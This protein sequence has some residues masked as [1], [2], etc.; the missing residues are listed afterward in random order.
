MNTAAPADLHAEKA[1]LGT[2]LKDPALHAIHGQG[3]AGA[4]FFDERHRFAA[5]A[6]RRCADAGTPITVVTVT[7]ELE[8]MRV[9]EAAGGVAFVEDLVEDC[10]TVI[11]IAHH[12]GI[13]R[14]L[15]EQR[16]L[17]AGLLNLVSAGYGAAAD[18]A[19]T[20]AGME[21]LLI[22]ARDGTDT[23]K[24]LH[25]GVHLAEA[26]QG[27][28]ARYQ[29]SDGPGYTTGIFGL[30]EVFAMRPP[31][32]IVVGGEPGSGKTALTEQLALHLAAR[33]QLVLIVSIEMSGE[34][35]AQRAIAGGLGV[36]MRRLRAERMDAGEVGEVGRMAGELSGLPIWIDDRSQPSLADIR[37]SVRR[38]SALVGKPAIVFVDYLGLM[39]DDGGRNDS[40]SDRATRKARGLRAMAKDFGCVV[41]A[42]TQLVKDPGC[43]G[44][45][46]R[47]T[48]ASIRDSKEIEA[49]ADAIVLVWRHDAACPDEA[50]NGEA[51]ILIAKQRNDK[52][53]WTVPVTFDG[54]AMK[55]SDSGGW[56]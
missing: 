44:E 9:L 41:V 6:M 55:F 21:R 47:P 30:D 13:V 46:R 45:K 10:G 14:R 38:L 48:K 8:R 31:D 25:F 24:P 23:A 56:R 39:A 16:R 1:V 52:F 12:V 27:A 5:D 26:Y 49:A 28:V 29:G 34:A 33:G 4:H 19:E 7:H 32:F 40:T 11:G 2:F 36:P 18:P 3:L 42:L 43:Y 53:P 54:V 22:D 51:E 20:R 17:L 37:S 15:A 35:L 50:P